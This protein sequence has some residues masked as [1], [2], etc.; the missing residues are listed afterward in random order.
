M[1]LASDRVVPC[2]RRAMRSTLNPLRMT[3]EAAVPLTVLAVDS[4]L[5]PFVVDVSS[6]FGLSDSFPSIKSSGLGIAARNACQ[7]VDNPLKT[8]HFAS[9][10]HLATCRLFEPEAFVCLAQLQDVTQI[11]RNIIQMSSP[12]PQKRTSFRKRIGKRLGGKSDGDTESPG[13]QDRDFDGSPLMTD[14]S[15]STSSP[16]GMPRSHSLEEAPHAPDLDSSASP[17]RGRKNVFQR[18]RE[19][20][21]SRSRSRRR[22]SGKGGSD[23]DAEESREMLVAVTSCRSDGYYNQKAPGSTSKL[24]RKAPTNLKLFHELA[25]G[26]KDAYLAVGATPRK[27]EEGDAQY[28]AKTTLWE[29]IGNLDF[30]SIPDTNV[31]RASFLAPLLISLTRSLSSIVIGI[32]RRSGSRYGHTW[33]LER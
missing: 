33:R 23:S 25:V 7:I 5:V 29:Y 16:R 27:P 19:R 17:S 10:E 30:V 22:G 2:R 1:A 4:P 11:T 8:V 26:V 13:N 31:S 9:P 6:L 12:N 15:P 18:I 32:G 24:P 21:R 20:S 28:E 14:V 3:A